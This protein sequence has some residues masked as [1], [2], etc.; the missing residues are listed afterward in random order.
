MK[1]FTHKTFS[2]KIF[3]A[4][5]F[6]FLTGIT[7][8]CTDKV[9]ITRKYK[10]FE[11]VYLSLP[12]LRSSFDVLPP[13]SIKKP[14]KIYLY[15]K[16]ILV[17]EYGKGIHIID[18]SN[19]AHPRVK[20]FLNIPG[21]FDM[22]V[23]GD[24]LYADSFMDLEVLDISDPENA[25]MLGRIEGIFDN[26]NPEFILDKERGIVIDWIEKEV[27]EVSSSDFGGNFPS[28]FYYG[29]NGI[30]FGPAAMEVDFA[31]NL[32]PAPVST[33]TGGSMA[34]FTIQGDYLYAIDMSNLHVFDITNLTKPEAGAK[35]EI[36]WGIETIFPYKKNLFI[37]S[38]TGLHIYDISSPGYPVRLSTLEHVLS[39]DPVVV[40]DTIAFVTLRSGTTCRSDFGD[41]LDVIDISNLKK[42]ELLTSFPMYNPHGLGVDGNL[43]FICEGEKGLEIYKTDDLLNISSNKIT[44][45]TGIDA[46]DVIP[47]RNTLLMIGNDGLYQFDYSNPEQIELLSTLPVYR[48]EKL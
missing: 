19:P 32:M 2:G 37:G 4:L 17:N 38:Q 47:Y 30:A 44:E 6:I 36:G 10:V 40:K 35:V 16:Y 14:G 23:K 33:G 11:P 7:I 28:Y 39:C 22:A 41:Q 8:Q 43:L 25:V 27:I 26:Y 15:E 42:P 21:N 48:N 34:R 9:E 45:F 24:I 29:R 20:K 13:D 3:S 18:N 12:E 1:I 46:Y 31:A 5:L